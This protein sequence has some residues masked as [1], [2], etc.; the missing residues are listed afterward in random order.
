MK[1]LVIEIIISNTIPR[2]VRILEQTHRGED[3]GKK[4]SIFVHKNFI[5]QSVN[6][7][8]YMDDPIAEDGRGEHGLFVRGSEDDAD[9]A[10]VHIPGYDWLHSLEEAVL[11]YNE[12][13]N[14]GKKIR[15]EDVIKESRNDDYINHHMSDDTDEW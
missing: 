15:R 11:A 12:F 2:V 3:F 5:L 13:F 7:V 4:D 8:A 10:I 9:N 14:K 6:I 1:K